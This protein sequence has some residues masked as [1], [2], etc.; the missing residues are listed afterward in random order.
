MKK[1]TV[2]VFLLS[3]MMLFA[4]G[5]AN[6]W[7]FGQNAGINFN[8]GAASPISGNLN[9]IEGCASFS[10]IGGNLLFYTDG[11]TVWDKNH[12]A[13][14]NGQNLLGDPSSTQSAIIVPHPG[15]SDLFYIFTVG[16]NDYDNDGNL[17]KATEGLNAYTVDMAARSG[18]GDVT[19]LV[20]NLSG[21]QSAN[22]TEKVTSVKGSAC[23]TFWVISLVGNKFVSYKIDP[24]GLISTP[25]NSFV[26]FQANDPRG[27]LKVSPDG[28][29]LVSATYGEGVVQLYR[30]NDTSGIVSN[31]GI[32]LITFPET[33]GYTY[34]VEFSS[35]STKLYCSTF[36]GDNNNRINKL[37]QFDL[38]NPN[39]VSSKFLV[40]TQTGFRGGLQLAPNG[41]IYATVPPD[42]DNGTNYLNAINIPDNLGAACS[43]ELN[44]LKL[45]S[46]YAMQGLPPFIASLLLPVEITDGITTQNMNNTTAKRCVGENYQLTAQNIEGDPIY[47]WTFNGALVG[48][49]DTL[50]LP[51]LST[52]DEGI[53]Y[54]EAETIDD[55]NF[56]ITY[57][58]EVKIEVYDPPTITKPSAILQCD[59]DIDGFYSFN[60]N[61][62]KDA[63]V[64]QSQDPTVFEV[65][66]FKTFEDAD[67]N[68]N[69][70]TM[71]F[72][73]AL[74][75]STTTII[76]RIQNIQNPICYE[77]ESFTI[78]VFET[79]NPPTTILNLAACDSNLVGYDTDGFEI[80]DLTS[81]EIEILNGQNPL[82]FTIS[83]FEDTALTS[84]ILNPTIY[85]N[86]KP[87]LQPIYVQIV[88]NLYSNCV[89]NTSFNIEIFKL[90]TIQNTFTFMQCD[91]DGVSDG[92]TSFNLNEAN[93]YLTLGDHS[94]NVSYY[95]SSNEASTAFNKINA[96][97]FSNKTKST[98]Y[99]RIENAH[100]CFRV[101]Q[102]DLLVSATHFPSDFLIQVSH[103][104]DDAIIDG[105]NLFNLSA[106]DADI[107]NA[108]PSGQN[109]SVSYYRNL[110]DAQLEENEI[111]K[112][113]PYLS[114][115]PY[116]QTLYV[117][118]ESE[119]NGACFGLGPHLALVVNERPQFELDDSDIYCQNLPPKT[120]SIKNADGKYTYSWTND[121]GVE[122]SDQ[123]FATITKEGNYTV[124]ATSVFGCESFPQ[125][126]NIEPSIIATIS[127]NDIEIIDD[128]I[129]NSITITT[130]NLGI[131]DYEFAIDNNNFNFQDAPYFENVDAGIHTIYIRDKN[132]CGVAQIA[133]S[134][135]GFPKFFTPNN[136]G[137][138]DT[139]AILGVN[140]TFYSNSKIYIFDRYGKFITSIKPN[141]VGWDGLFNGQQLPATDYWFTAE[142]IDSTGIIRIR[143]GH[144]SLIRS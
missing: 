75:Y 124:I 4:Q 52:A 109:L 65:V 141:E 99:A 123:P 129:N 98:V 34:G 96:S 104:D 6:H 122:I 84:P 19:G 110:V 22:W 100:G 79:P 39:I 57:K 92:F 106:H 80:F 47:R 130:T 15:N 66:Y 70:I 137:H 56:T 87:N 81:K 68:K 1:I 105:L 51:N 13:M 97:P 55:C 58:G 35:N 48:A 43:F 140:E 5:E 28:K 88:N 37:F 33:D 127:E 42:Y 117:R 27:Y 135:L 50:N 113:Q 93:E 53:Y 31:D 36:N 54:F 61:I 73:N 63:E 128:T 46:G 91:E 16:A 62:L 86:T 3:S 49:T 30:F 2:V 114:E 78:Q 95:L 60:L 101:S 131:G 120:I 102:V 83:Y 133:V 76:A 69:P 9:T 118:L 14:T 25:I 103:C 11:I 89:V 82:N 85:K 136:D 116:K 126:I 8:N 139:W 108:L 121:S 67:A 112:N 142:L 125:M 26:S 40:N 21:G 38:N 74:P 134:V 119:D 45:N 20:I 41:K 132:Q 32:S 94:L 111:P 10:D 7:F 17:I 24:T 138:N 44:A 64:M 77:T 29:R 72:T 18:L 115:V 59:N 71:P 107:K 144:F 12:N 90:P 143:K 23:D